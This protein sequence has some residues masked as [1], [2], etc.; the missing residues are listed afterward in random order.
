MVAVVILI[1]CNNNRASYN[2]DIEGVSMNKIVP[3]VLIVGVLG[4]GAY[5]VMRGN[6]GPQSESAAQPI[7]AAPSPTLSSTTGSSGADNTVSPEK[8][9]EVEGGM[10]YFKPNVITVKK[11][12]TVKITLTNKEG[13][14]DFVIDEFNVKTK[15]IKAGE[16][17][18]VTF[19]A[20]KTGSFEYYCSVG[21]HR[22]MGMK[23][24]L[25]VE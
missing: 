8:P 21:T 7:T 2:A 5:V 11:G 6:G 18:T 20:D 23:G 10:Y 19:V 3:I 13:M 22:A 16:T 14:H 1:T 9:F 4:I 12:D 15:R 25:I 17:D 24:K